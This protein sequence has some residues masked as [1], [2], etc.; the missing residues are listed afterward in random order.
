MLQYDKD[1]HMAVNDI[2]TLR[3]VGRY[4]SQNIVNTMH[5]RISAQDTDNDSILNVLVASWESDWESDWVARHSDQ[6]TLVG[7]KAFRQTGEAKRPA[8][9][10]ISEPGTVVGDE[11]PAS[12]CR[13]I[14]LYTDDTDHRRRGRLMLSGTTLSMLNQTDGSVTTTELAAL[15][16]LVALCT[17][18]LVNV[19]DSFTPCLPHTAGKTDYDISSA[20]PRVTPASVTSRRV[21]QYLIG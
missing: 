8:F 7:L 1:V 13:T 4:Q 11:L 3:I 20:H 10:T 21:K 2:C 5:Y 18:V 9:R 17:N 14:T 16:N 6:Y 15:N 19:D 12:I